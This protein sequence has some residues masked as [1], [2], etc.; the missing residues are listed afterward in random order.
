MLGKR[1]VFVARQKKMNAAMGDYLM[2][3]AMDSLVANIRFADEEGT[4]D[5]IAVVSSIPGEGK[6]TIAFELART[7]AEGDDNVILVDCD[8]R[9][10]SLAHRFGVH[11]RTGLYSVMLGRTSI[12]SAVVKTPIEGVYLLDVEPSMPNPAGTFGSVR[13]RN[14]VKRLAG[15][16]DYVV[17]DTPPLA[18]FVD[19]ALVAASS[20][21]A[22][23][24]ARWDY[25]KRGDVKAAVEQLRTAGANTIGTV[26][27]CYPVGRD[28]HYYGGKR[29]GASDADAP[30][31]MGKPTPTPDGTDGAGSS[32]AS[33]H[34]D[35][36]APIVG[37]AAAAHASGGTGGD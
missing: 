5:S 31:I 8:V 7:L 14:L 21:A 2:R 30:R 10:R 29:G 27:N 33:A 37:G 24:V 3:S 11:P 1:V 20:D 34:A 26:V 36:G 18:N 16:F 12:Q 17:L 32:G 22:V 4:T 23:M 13:F 28:Y 25:T 6:S 19:G 15:A 35:A 9:H